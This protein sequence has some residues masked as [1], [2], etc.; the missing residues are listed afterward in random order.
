MRRF[1]DFREAK[2]QVDTDESLNESRSLVRKGAATVFTL[3]S[4]TH[5]NTAQT[6]FRRSLTALQ[7]SKSISTD[8]KID[9]LSDA[10]QGVLEGL[11]EMTKQLNQTTAVS[12][13]SALL[14]ERSDKEILSLLR[15]SPT[16]SR[17]T[18]RRRR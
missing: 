7:S 15:Q 17:T 14:N 9:T 3:Q 16:K 11:T 4:R 12:A 5:A 6:A 13:S 2:N 8:E 1:T 18:R 10:L